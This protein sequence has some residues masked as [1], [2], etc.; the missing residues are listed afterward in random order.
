MNE[1]GAYLIRAIL[2]GV[3]L[4]SFLFATTPGICGP[5]Q[6]LTPEEAALVW[7]QISEANGRAVVP[8]VERY[9]YPGI[10]GLA[11]DVRRIPHL[12]R[13]ATVDPFPVL[14]EVIVKLVAGYGAYEGIVWLK[15]KLEDD[16]KDAQGT[17]AAVPMQS[18]AGQAGATPSGRDNMTFNLSN[19]RAEVNITVNQLPEDSTDE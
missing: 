2:L 15:D 1:R 11:V 14:G 13:T 7:Q 3:G 8:E 19:I 17:A 12:V 16:D 10:I 9:D 4:L 6:D 18:A 5:V